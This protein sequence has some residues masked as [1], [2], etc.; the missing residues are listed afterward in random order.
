VAR[1]ERR[2]GVMAHTAPDARPEGR[3]AQ[4]ATVVLVTGANRGLGK[5]VVRQL[6]HRGMTVL[7]GSRDLGRG[8]A[9]A[10]SLRQAGSPPVTPVQFDVTDRASVEAAAELLR[11]EYGRLDVLVN[12]AGVFTAATAASLTA[13]QMRDLFEVNVFGVVR[14]I[15]T[16]LP[17]LRQSY[18][19]R[20]VNVSSATASLTDTSTGAQIPGDAA[21]RAGYA[22]SKAALNMLTVQY[23]T[24]FAADPG[25]S[26]MK[27]N[28]A[29]P[30]YTA[31]DMNQHRGTHPVRTGARV[32][33]D[34]ATLPDDGPTGG[35]FADRGPLAW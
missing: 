15:H 33:V 9:T 14:A 7:L 17:L 18:A 8:T 20:I 34:L 23:A 30:A 6:S 22:S 29:A 16:L 24:A 11:R 10:R 4:A 21:V 27:V 13:D 19:P 32:I 31:T 2:I 3:A 12:N 5:E 26:R 28:S 1:H 35:F 25:L